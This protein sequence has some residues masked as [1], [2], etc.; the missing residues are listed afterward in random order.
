[1]HT[2]LAL[3]L[4][5][6]SLLNTEEPGAGAPA[7]FLLGVASPMDKVFREGTDYTGPLNGPVRIAAAGRER[8]SFQ[9]VCVPLAAPDML[10]RRRTRKTRCWPCS[11]R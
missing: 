5:L 8:E 2:A 1:M 11:T 7:P 6:I 4:A 10:Q 9:V 3:S